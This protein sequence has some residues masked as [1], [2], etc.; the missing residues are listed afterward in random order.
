MY[1]EAGA[2]KTTVLFTGVLPL[3]HRRADDAVLGSTGHASGLARFPERRRRSMDSPHAELAIFFDAWNEQPVA[4]LRKQICAA[5]SIDYAE[6]QPARALADDLA[7]WS[8]DFG[9]RFLI[10]LDGFERYL[11][12]PPDRH[13]IEQFAR[14]F[15][16]AVTK[17]LLPAHF[18][19]SVRDDAEVLLDRFRTRIAGFDNSSF[20]LPP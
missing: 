14:E 7:T 8:K 9:V 5:L 6:A 18:L 13:D 16:Q 19:I 17:P 4:A 15:S 2:G 20:R 11:T 10:L 1:G 12:A 3:L